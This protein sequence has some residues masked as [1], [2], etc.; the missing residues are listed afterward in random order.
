M[1][2]TIKANID[3]M[4]ESEPNNERTNWI[5]RKEGVEQFYYFTTIP[6]KVSLNS[7]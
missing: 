5:I 3:G 6:R 4:L 2:R 7:G 1:L